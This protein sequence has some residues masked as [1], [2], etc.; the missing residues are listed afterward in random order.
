M[1]MKKEYHGIIPP[2]LTP[3]DKN[4]ELDIAGL[5]RLLERMISGG[6]HGL[7][8]LGTTGEGPMLGSRIQRQMIDETVR[9]VRKRVPVLAGVSDMSLVNSVDLTLYAKSA[10]I[11][12]IVAAAPCYM[13]LGDRDMVDFY[14]ELSS[15]GKMP[16]F[17]YNMPSMTKSYLPPSLVAELAEIPGVRGYKDSSGNMTDFYE[18]IRHLGG[19]EDFSIFIGPEEMLAES[20]LAGADG[21]V[22]GGANLDPALF[23]SMYNAAANRDM[24]AVTELRR[25]IYIQ[26]ELYSAANTPDRIIRG[27]KCALKELGV[28]ESYPV[29]PGKPLNDAEK[30]KVMEIVSRL[31]L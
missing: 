24:D 13:T 9:I 22:S 6:V 31:G 1:F 23:V 7:F 16:L 4:Y 29:P 5:E 30:S 11:D 3:L 17:V 12:G 21:G 25:K 14:R 26:R 8:I 15:A 18:V 2:V 28:C 19:R 20:V 10:G 27:L